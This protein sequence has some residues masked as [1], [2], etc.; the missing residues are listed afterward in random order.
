M[1][2]GIY[3]RTQTHKDKLSFIKIGKKRPDISGNKNGR[4]KGGISTENEKIRHSLESKLWQ[5]S[6]KNRDGN[7]CQKCGENR[8]SKLTAHHILNFS[9]HK[10]LRFAIDNGIALCRNCHKEFHMKYK[11]TNNTREQIDS[12]IK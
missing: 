10:E 8:I 5:D 7:R 6:V 3:K 12:F 11:Y 4:W 1:P 2:S 9:S